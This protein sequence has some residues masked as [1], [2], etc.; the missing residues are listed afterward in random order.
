MSTLVTPLVRAQH[1]RPAT[2]W[3]FAAVLAFLGLSAVGGGVAML[4]GFTPPDNW[5]DDIPLIGSWMIPGLVLGL[6]FGAGS[7]VTAYGVVRRPS[8]PWLAGVERLIGHHWSWAAGLLLGLGQVTWIALEL[9]YLP[10]GSA[11]QAVYGTTGV[12]LVLLPTLPAVRR[13]LAGPR[14]G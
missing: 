13:D 6:G 4:C 7:L 10:E 14:S 2:V 8:W 1:H 11:L 12:L 5:L 9:A 3:M